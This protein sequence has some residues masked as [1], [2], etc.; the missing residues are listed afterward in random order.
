MKLS[1]TIAAI[2]AALLILAGCAGRSPAQPPVSEQ[3]YYP[4]PTCEHPVNEDPADEPSSSSLGL[5]V[6]FPGGAT[7]DYAS[8]EEMAA[9][10][11]APR[12]VS[13]DT[14]IWMVFRFDAP[15]RDVVFAGMSPHFAEET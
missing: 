15:V 4:E 3:Q 12:F 2:C 9:Y 14:G 5:P 1:L 7:I 11:D 10:P 6:T 8:E 13:R